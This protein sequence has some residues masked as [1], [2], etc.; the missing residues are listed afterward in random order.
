M[1]TFP[2]TMKTSSR[3]HSLPALALALAACASPAATYYWKPGTTAADYGTLSNW[4]TESLSGPDAAALPGASDALYPDADYAFDLGGGSYEIGD[5]NKDGTTTTPG[6]TLSVTNGSLTVTGT[7]KPSPVTIAVKAGGSLVF[8]S[9]S[10]YYPGQG[11]GQVCTLS[12]EDGGS[13]SILNNYNLRNSVLNVAS[14][15]TLVFHPASYFGATS[16][17]AANSAGQTAINNA[18]TLDLPGGIAWNAGGASGYRAELNQTGGTMNLGGPIN[19]AVSKR[20]LDYYVSFSGGTVNVT[21]DSAVSN[22]KSATLSGDTTWNVAAGKTANLSGVAVSAGTTVA[23]AGAG[24]LVL[25]S[26]PAVFAVTNGSASL[27]ATFPSSTALSAVDVRA[28]GT[29]AV[30]A[31]GASIAELSELAGTLAISKPG[32]SVAAVGAN[33]ALPGAVEVDLASFAT[34]GTVVS[35]PSAA[36]RAKVLAAAEAAIADAGAALVASDDGTA[37]VL[38]AAG[39]VKI[40]ES[41]TVTDLADAAGWRDGE[42]PAAGEPALVGGA[43]VTGTLT[44]A[45]LAKG[46]SRIDVANGA[47]LRLAVAP[48]ALPVSFDAGTALAVGPGVA[49]SATLASGAPSL[50]LEPGATLAVGSG[51]TF[52][53][54]AGVTTEATAAALS[55]I[56]VAAGGTLRTPSGG[57]AFKDVSL[58]L[59]G[60][61][62]ELGSLDAVTFGT[63]AAGATNRFAMAATNAVIGPA[64]SVSGNVLGYRFACPAAGGAVAVAGEIVLKNT[65]ISRWTKGFALGENNPT[66][67]PFAVVLDNSS[68]TWYKGALSVAGAGTLVVSNGTVATTSAANANDDRLS[69]SGA[70]QL[71]VGSGGTV[72]YP[73]A[74]NGNTRVELSGPASDRPAIVLA[75]GVFEPY[76]MSATASAREIRVTDDSVW[77]VFEDT[78]W[79]D[80]IRNVL[81]DGAARTTLD[82]GATLTVR[83]RRYAN[84]EG[85]DNTGVWIGTG[86]IAGG[87]DLVLTNAYAGKAFAVA[88]RGGSNTCSGELRA[89]DGSTLL[90]AD[91]CNW[92]GVLVANGNVAFTNQADAAAAPARIGLGGVRF[93]ADLPIR[94]W[95]DGS[96]D[97]IDFGAAGF[98]GEGA[99]SLEL[100]GGFRPTRRGRWSVGTIPAGEPLPPLAERAYSLSAR[101]TETPGVLELR[102]GYNTATVILIR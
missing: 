102:L 21:G 64:E 37:V 36:L 26:V 84:W 79:W 70:G 78:Y 46:W 42:I 72:F 29:L 83:N 35:T 5:W 9:G 38:A 95:E 67:L 100:V 73:V 33:A 41:T 90:L 101:E 51:E 19:G 86:E 98:T 27:A 71:V 43:G 45:A 2:R 32:L 82:E 7:W 3:T 66:N 55:E 34:G 77:Q 23:K 4:S 59:D 10:T 88:L 13:A 12:V 54:S 6:R 75:G 65:T 25:P 30:D 69:V 47:T 85:N 58:V 18:G 8:G 63:A 1:K 56:R 20:S 11:S 14:G 97:A 31:S 48:G 50:V 44:A 96:S 89:T 76:K 94:L 99:L 17:A 68:F 52:A 53:L 28:G 24:A 15:G 60:G 80:G 22:C 61:A 81:F 57:Y 93:E 87:G 40:F 49:V 39:A 74:N 62:L 16:S 91:G 92:A